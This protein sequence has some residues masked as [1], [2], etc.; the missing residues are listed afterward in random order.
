[1]SQSK[2]TEVQPNGSFVYQQGPLA[3]KTGYGF[4]YKF[5]DGTDGRCVHMTEQPKFSVGDTVDIE[6]AGNDPQGNRKVKLSKQGGSYRGGGGSSGGSYDGG[7]GAMVGNS[8]TN[9]TT[10]LCHG[11]A[12]PNKGESLHECLI[13]LGDEYCIASETLKKKHTP[14]APAP[15]P[16]QQS[17]QGQS[18]PQQQEEDDMFDEDDVPF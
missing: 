6:E 4:I 10:L 2:I 15:Q 5:E 16:Q 14:A 3:G 9:A 12:K 8:L 1:M 11:K 17:S 7:V 18:Q 13:R